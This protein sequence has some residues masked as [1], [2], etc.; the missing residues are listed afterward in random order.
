MSTVKVRRLPVIDEYVED[1]RSA[2]LVQGK[3]FALSEVGTS[4]LALLGE[5][6]TTVEQLEAGL[7]ETVGVPEEGS[8]SEALA[9]FLDELVSHRLIERSEDGESD[10]A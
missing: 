8:L 3:V 10:P 2:V 9:P 6:W 4:V 1:G 7:E 5:E